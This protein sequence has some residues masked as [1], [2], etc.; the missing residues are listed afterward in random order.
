ML[1]GNVL[2]PKDH[3]GIKNSP[4]KNFVYIINQILYSI[5]QTLTS[6]AN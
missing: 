4:I 1:Q 3:N 2:L 5:D 6:Y